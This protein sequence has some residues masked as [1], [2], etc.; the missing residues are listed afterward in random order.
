[1]P[2]AIQMVEPESLWGLSHYVVESNDGEKNDVSA[3]L[4]SE[5]CTVAWRHVR[6]SPSLERCSKKTR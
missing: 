4:R 3:R 6:W 5:Q 2:A 1:M